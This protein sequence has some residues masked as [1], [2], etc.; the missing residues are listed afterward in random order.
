MAERILY[1]LYLYSWRKSHRGKGFKGCTP[2]CYEEWYSCELEDMLSHPCW[3]AY[4]PF[5]KFLVN[6]V[7][8][9]R[10]KDA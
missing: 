4:A 5:L 9:K 7:R 10:I 2:A 8:K 3:Y 6:S 1:L